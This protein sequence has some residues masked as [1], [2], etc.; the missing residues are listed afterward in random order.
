MIY[1]TIPQ[2]VLG[3]GNPVADTD[4]YVDD[5]VQISSAPP[6]RSVKF[7]D[8]YALD[9]PL[10]SRKRNFSA[11][12]SNKPQT[13]A[14]LIDSYFEFLAGEPINNF[15]IL[16]VTATVVALQWSKSFRA[17]DTYTVRASFKEVKR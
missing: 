4:V 15:H 13:T 12:M 17:S 1:F 3:V 5:G 2:D 14:D 6:T 10:G 16:G 7:G 8:D 9:I 11:T